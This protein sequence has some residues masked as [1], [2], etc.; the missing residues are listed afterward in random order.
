LFLR[1]DKTVLYRFM[2]KI[3]VY[4]CVELD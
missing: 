2:N 4:F 3:Q 1:S